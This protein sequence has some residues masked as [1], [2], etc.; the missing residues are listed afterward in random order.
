VPAAEHAR[1]VAAIIANVRRHSHTAGPHLG[2][3]A[4]AYAARLQWSV[5]PLRACE[6]IPATAHG[7]K[8]ASRDTHQIRQWWSQMPDANIGIATGEVS[9]FFAFDI[10]P[11]HG[12]DEELRALERQHGELPVTVRQLTGGG[13]EHVLFRHVLGLRNSAGKLGPGLDIRAD[14]GYIV[15]APS[16]HPNRR[17][18]A[19]SVD[20]HPLEVPIAEAPPWLIERARGPEAGNPQGDGL[21]VA[22]SP[23]DWVEALAQPCPE[24]RRNDTLTRL[25][26]HLLRHYVDPF[27]VLAI[28]DNWNRLRCDPPL[29]DGELLHTVNS[30]ANREFQR[31]QE[32]QHG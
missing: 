11:A 12:G 31:R 22:R 28:A 6:K 29:A 23:E 25:V 13:G 1:A 21:L 30:I 5:F 15:A 3:A 32:V 9:G 24:G 26:G 17:R 16:L 2:R 19:W 20:G 7:L 8:D 4:R 10:D 27:V 14:G 18:Y